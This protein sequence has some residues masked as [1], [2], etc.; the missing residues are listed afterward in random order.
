V[1]AEIETCRTELDIPIAVSC[2][3][4]DVSVSWF[5]K[6][7]DAIPTP[8]RQRR[9]E[10]DEAIEKVFVEQSGEYGSPRV[11]AELVDEHGY[12]HLSVNTVAERMRAKGLRAKKKRRGRSLTKADPTAPKFSN[13]L[14]RDF[15][16]AVINTS[17]VGDITEIETWEGKLYLATVIDLWSRRLIGFAVAENCKA[18]LV[19]DAMRMAIATRGGRDVVAGVTFHSDRAGQYTAGIFTKL[20]AQNN[21]VQSMSRS[22]CCLDNA[23]AEAF[24]A[25]F[26]TELI[27][28]TVLPTMTGARH[29]I[30]AW[31]DLC[32]SFV[33]GASTGSSFEYLSYLPE[34]ATL[35]TAP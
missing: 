24:F 10:L 35:G 6:H 15:K 19:C 29:E 2:R 27:Y 25:S 9:D 33:V 8:S 11:L 23:A 12:E 30:V 31:L 1:I 14:K 7:R 34:P 20:C 26:K 3:A 18:P 32:P 28:R 5:Y 16:P 13:L 4:L 22:G 17:W 21:I